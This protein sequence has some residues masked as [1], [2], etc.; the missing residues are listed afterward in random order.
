MEYLVEKFV[1][2]IFYVL[3]FFGLNFMENI[4]VYFLVFFVV[5]YVG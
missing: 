5:K 4:F 3:D 2:E 1:H